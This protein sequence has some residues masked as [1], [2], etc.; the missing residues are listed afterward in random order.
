MTYDRIYFAKL[1]FLGRDQVDK[2]ADDPRYTITREGLIYYVDGGV[3]G[4]WEV[5]ATN[6]VSARRVPEKATAA[7][8]VKAR[9]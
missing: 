7:T 9:G 1:T 2:I 8:P 4:A 5:P 3:S 6:V